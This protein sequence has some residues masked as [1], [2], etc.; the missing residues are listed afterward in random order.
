MRFSLHLFKFFNNILKGENMKKIKLSFLLVALG[1]LSAC[2]GNNP[3]NPSNNESW[4]SNTIQTQ[5]IGMSGDS[6][7]PFDKETNSMLNQL[8][9]VISPFDTTISVIRYQ[10]NQNF[11]D[12]TS[13][14]R[15][16]FSELHAY[17]DSHYDYKINGN[18]INNL[19]T[20]NDHYGDGE[21][22][23][24]NDDLY[25]ILQTAVRVTEVADGYYNIGIGALSDL[26]KE[27]IN[28]NKGNTSSARPIYRKLYTNAFMMETL[29][30][31]DIT[32]ADEAKGIYE[33]ILLLVTDK[34]TF[35]D[36]Q[37]LAYHLKFI[38]GEEEAEILLG[39]NSQLKINA[40][41]LLNGDEL[42]SLA[43]LKENAVSSQIKNFTKGSNLT[44]FGD[45]NLD[46]KFTQLLENVVTDASARLEKT[47]KGMVPTA[48]EVADAKSA[49]PSGEEIASV[50]EFK[51]ENNKKYVRLNKLE[52]AEQDV[53]LSLGSIGKGYAVKK[54]QEKLDP[55]GIAYVN[56]GDSSVSTI[57]D[58][59]FGAW[60]LAIT[61]PLYGEAVNQGDNATAQ[62]Y[63]SAEMRL[64]RQGS[65]SFSTS[66]DYVNCYFDSE[67]QRYH[68]IINPITGYPSNT[69]RTVSAICSDSTFADAITTGLMAMTMD[70]G[71]EFI[72]NLRSQYSLTIY[73]IWTV[74][75][76]ASLK[77]YADKTLEGQLKVDRGQETQNI[78]TSLE[79]IEI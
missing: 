49:V 27:Y 12:I 77:V 45:S 54:M 30:N 62:K 19:K 20:I 2:Q 32:Y 36:S 25:S 42:T 17:F 3:F 29:F 1:T 58:N 68:H 16:N 65:F 5:I 51:K 70:E 15:N 21:F 66:G 43:N 39:F 44:I 73:P 47:K 48:S 31:Y 76:G 75:D 50:V 18:L 41:T 55:N 33:A 26:W 61:N 28:Y 69:F 10:N 67:G 7:Q 6:V 63:N 57:N 56:G 78:V 38:N 22:I 8:D 23:E 64:S 59:M 34:G 52:G 13:L 35:E 79:F 11:S 24:V 14:V 40:Y 4:Y 71:K 53:R 60:R 46:S 72:K 9:A 74:Q 37:N